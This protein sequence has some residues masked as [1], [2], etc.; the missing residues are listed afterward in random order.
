MKKRD[1]VRGFSVW[2]PHN[3]FHRLEFDNGYFYGF[4]NLSRDQDF[5]T[6]LLQRMFLSSKGEY[7]G[8][9]WEQE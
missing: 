3:Q 5:V 2:D 9:R 6:A 8:F 7:C 1:E 4:E